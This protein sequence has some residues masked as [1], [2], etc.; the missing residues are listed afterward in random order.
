MA[1]QEP[2]ARKDLI[3]YWLAHADETVTDGYSKLKE[4]VEYRKEVADKVGLGFALPM[5]N[6]VVVP[7]VPN[8][9]KVPKNEATIEVALAV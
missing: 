2:N 3:R 5:K 1:S 8:V 4:D 7:N 9:P 6:P